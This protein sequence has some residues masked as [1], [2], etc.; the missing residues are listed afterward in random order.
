MRIENKKFFSV[1]ELN[2]NKLK[3]WEKKEYSKIRHDL[4]RVIEGQ[5]INQKDLHLGFIGLATQNT[6]L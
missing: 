3:N 1:S 2:L 4:K 6:E 5:K